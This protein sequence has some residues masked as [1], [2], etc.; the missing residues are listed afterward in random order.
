M[1][2]I[3]ILLLLALLPGCLINKPML[4]R[5]VTV[6]ESNGVKTTTT[7][8]SLRVPNYAVWPATS[9]V[10]KQ[11]VSMGKTLSSGTDAIRED[12]SGGTNGVATLEAL[13]RLLGQLG[14]S[15]K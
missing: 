15:L 5:K 3:A 9:A 7:E 4:N 13:S 6:N 12:A 2:T 8:E 1:R 11:K 10:E 14:L